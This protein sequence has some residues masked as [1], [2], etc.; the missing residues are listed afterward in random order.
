MLTIPEA[1]TKEYEDRTKNRYDYTKY[2]KEPY[3]LEARAQELARMHEHDQKKREVAQAKEACNRNL[4]A[5]SIRHFEPKRPRGR[6][7]VTGKRKTASEYSRAWRLKNPEKFKQCTKNWQRK[8][9]GKLKEYTKKW[10]QTHPEQ[11]KAIIKKYQST[12]KYKAKAR[13]VVKVWRE[14]HPE[15]V[16]EYIEKY[17]WKNL[18]PEQKQKQKDAQKRSNQ[19]HSEKRRARDRAYYAKRKNDPEF[20]KK[21]HER[22]HRAYLKIKADPVR[23]RHY[24]DMKNARRRLRMATDPAYKARRHESERKSRAKRQGTRE[25]KIRE[26]NTSGKTFYQLH[27]DEPE[28]K[29]KRLEYSIKQRLK[30]GALAHPVDPVTNRA[31]IEHG[32]SQYVKHK[33]EPEYRKRRRGYSVTYRLKK[34]V[35]IHPVDPENNR[36]ITHSSIKR[37]CDK[38][39]LEGASIDFQ[40]L[41]G[42]IETK[43]KESA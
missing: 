14:K 9:P 15:K 42:E 18:T 2:L 24:L 1:I 37:K 38:G 22:T 21:Q 4:F 31:I 28:F 16:K 13:A 40:N 34:G 11:W 41:L 26:K 33:N 19:K 25:P 12:P 23:H 8:H 7:K 17:A 3:Q 6:P 32:Q 36:A 5:V 27:K 10:I 35:K 43:S 20:K 29:K 39:D 30:K